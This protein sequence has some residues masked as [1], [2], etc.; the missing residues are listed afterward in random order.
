MDHEVLLKKAEA[1]RFLKKRSP[2]LLEE[3]REGCSWEEAFEYL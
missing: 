3:C 1:K 2:G